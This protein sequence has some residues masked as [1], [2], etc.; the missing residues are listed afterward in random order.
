[1]YCYQ[2]TQAVAVINVAR[3]EAFQERN[4]LAELFPSD[5]DIFACRKRFD[6]ADR[7]LVLETEAPPVSEKTV[8][9]IENLANGPIRI[10]RKVCARDHSGSR[11]V[12]LPYPS[13]QS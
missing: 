2:Q 1:M 8:N 12:P 9:M 6:L 3:H 13:S 5:H 7:R 11:A 10:V 4:A